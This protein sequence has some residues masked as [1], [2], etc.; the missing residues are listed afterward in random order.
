MSIGALW[1]IFCEALRDKEDSLEIWDD[2]GITVLLWGFLIL[3]ILF[4]L[5]ILYIAF[6]R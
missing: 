2:T 5:G 4:F 3:S 6:W 1:L